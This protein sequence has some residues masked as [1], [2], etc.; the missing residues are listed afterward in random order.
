MS[1]QDAAKRIWPGQDMKFRIEQWR[2]QESYTYRRK[3]MI[4]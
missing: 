2:V 3:R 1:S 4:S